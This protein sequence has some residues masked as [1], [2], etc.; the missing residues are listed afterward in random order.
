MA[1]KR[2]NKVSCWAEKSL[3]FCLLFTPLV[4][5]VSQ[6]CGLALVMV[7]VFVSMEGEG[8]VLVLKGIAKWPRGGIPFGLAEKN[9]HF[10]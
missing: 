9:L 8:P 4:N 2:I 3:F 1:L 5:V 10:F 7:H 6:K